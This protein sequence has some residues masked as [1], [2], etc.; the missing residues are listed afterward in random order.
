VPNFCYAYE[1]N[2]EIDKLSKQYEIKIICKEKSIIDSEMDFT[3][4]EANSEMIKNSFKPIEL[5]FL[6]YEKSFLKEKIKSLNLFNKI[7]FRGSSA[8]GIHHNGHI[9][10][11]IGNYPE[12]S[13]NTI[14]QEILHH[15]FSSIIYRQSEF[16]KKLVWK[17]ISPNYEYSI[18]FLKKCLDNIEFGNA[19][20][21]DILHKGFLLNYS[22]TDDENDFN[23]YAEYMFV[24]PKK[25]K[26][27]YQRHPLVV[28]KAKLFKEFYR[29]AGYTGK[30]PDE[31]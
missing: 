1:C 6:K 25:I 8:G 20:G 24:H 14:Y 22:A 15:E 10:L 16:E 31:T 4:K 18:K 28:K 13:I 11:T 9:W 26:S 30:F 23:V 27:F 21:E 12:Y 19:S 3:F 29:E 2:E 7:K 5:F 17:K